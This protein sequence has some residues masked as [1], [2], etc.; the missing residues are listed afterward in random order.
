M[1]PAVIHPFGLLTAI[2]QTNQEGA[3]RRERVRQRRGD[4]WMTKQ[5]G[6]MLLPD[7][8]ATYAQNTKL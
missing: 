1:A 2:A 6:K 3:E 7:D 4:T 8:V 5:R